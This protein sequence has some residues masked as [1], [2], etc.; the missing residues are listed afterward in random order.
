MWNNIY[1]KKNF[2]KLCDLLIV[3]QSENVNQFIE[4]HT[5]YFVHFSIKKYL[6]KINSFVFT[7]QVYTRI[8]INYFKYLC[9][10]NFY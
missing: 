4:N 10:D 2:L 7:L 1:V 8:I 6:L 5:I 3:V 9:Y